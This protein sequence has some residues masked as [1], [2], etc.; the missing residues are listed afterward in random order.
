VLL[1][2][3]Y[4]H[5]GSHS[6]RQFFP[7]IS[8]LELDR[9]LDALDVQAP[10]ATAATTGRGRPRTGGKRAW[11]AVRALEIDLDTRLPEGNLGTH[12]LPFAATIAPMPARVDPD[13]TLAVPARDAMDEKENYPTRYHA[14]SPSC[15]PLAGLD[16][17]C[18]ARTLYSRPPP[19]PTTRL[20][21]TTGA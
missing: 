10:R 2:L 8:G 20:S 18:R 11:R 13:L 17:F 6:L 4:I 12:F 5:D 3:F 19:R 15:H 9:A 21:R 16:S 14:H 7:H 1:K